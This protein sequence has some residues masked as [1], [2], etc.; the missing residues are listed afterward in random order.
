MKRIILFSVFL[1]LCSFHMYAQSSMTDEQV[2]RYVMKEH[3]AGTSQSQIITKLMQ[4]G[5]DIQQIRRVKKTYERVAKDKGLGQVSAGTTKET[6]NDRM[7][8]NNGAEKEDH[9]SD[10]KIKAADKA[11]ERTAYDKTNPDFRQMQSELSDILPDSIIIR[12]ERLEAELNKK[13]VFGRDIFN[14]KDL[15]FEPNMNIAT[16]QNYRIGPGDAVI[17]D[18]YGASQKSEQLT[19]SPDGDITIEGFGPVQVSGLTVAQANA[20]L[21]ST[22]GSRY[23]SSR[24][25]LTVGQTRTI[26]VNVM[27][28][29]KAP[30]TYTLS[31]FASVFHAL[32]MAGGINDLGTLRNIKVYRN[33]KLVTTVDIYDYI[34]NGKLTGNIR[35]ADN[36]V[37]VVGA[38]DCLVNITGKVKRPMYYE[39]KKN[40]S[41]GTLIKYA[42][43]FTG[44]AYKKSVRLIR[45]TGREF[46]V[47]SVD[48]FDMNTF[49]LA[50]ADSVS[51][52]SILQRYSN[53]VEVKGAVFRPGMYQVGGNIN[54]VRTLLEY[55]E[56]FT[57][58]AFTA[59][60]VMHRMRPDRTLEVIPVDVEGIMNGRVADIPLQKNDVLFIPTKAEMMQQQ[61]ITIHGEVVYPG[62]Y[63]YAANETLEDLVLQAGG[64]KESASTVKVDVARRIINS[65]ALTTDSVIS[66]TYTFA[67]KDGFVIDGQPGFTLQPFD[68]V[69]VRKS[70]GYNEQKNI[71]VR[72]QV[73]F[74]GTY[75]LVSKNERLTDA[76]KK[77]GGITDMAYVKGARLER[78]ITPDE[79]LRMETVLK[80]AKMQSGKKDSVDINSLD[81]GDTYYVGIELDKALEK[82]GGDADLVLREGDRIIVPEYNGTV[83]ISGN[84]MYPNT[85][86]Y[87]KGKRPS[88]YIDQAGGFGNRAKKGSTYIIYMNGTVAR[89]GHNAKIRPG[90]EIV[91]PTKPESN[92]KGLAQWLSIGTSVAGIATMIATIANLI[93]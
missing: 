93:K 87:E 35:L 10:F 62:I 73:M 29:V 53:M 78:R 77:A 27:G 40:E 22:L 57:E 76:I 86:A 28:E 41:V 49:H 30:G 1:A 18:V 75:T 88:W 36:D 5:V 64:L 74:A 43:G 60:A 90:C 4:R 63:K 47:F 6:A 71:E 50:D 26:M 38:Y 56:G 44:D 79:R 69:Y 25:R 54:S 16:P 42:G 14:R 15:S 12:D 61:T 34:L 19:V 70:P 39:M 2:L 24:V 81:L 58:E 13:K 82:P 80:L 72:G 91:V 21:R 20:R 45:K 68:E 31:A 84:V 37:I 51:V 52:D 8:K 17:I 65:K 83:K 66:R 32:Y 3:E 9:N 11:S 33:N 85:V 89:V 46:S 59:H 48:E 92:G 23:S 55:A 7:R 67:L